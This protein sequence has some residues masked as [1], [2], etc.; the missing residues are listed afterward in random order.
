MFSPVKS[1]DVD[2]VPQYEHDPALS[3]CV[4]MHAKV[5][6][7]ITILKTLIHPST[8][9]EHK[10]QG[11]IGSS[12]ISSYREKHQE[13]DRTGSSSHRSRAQGT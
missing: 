8:G 10:E 11:R 12:P 6:S 2:S 9:P 1:Q 13:E 5:K 3:P 4:G 7:G